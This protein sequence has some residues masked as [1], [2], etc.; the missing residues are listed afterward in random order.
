MIGATALGACF[1]Y[2]WYL[3]ARLNKTGDLLASLVGNRRSICVAVVCFF[4]QISW[5]GEALSA[6]TANTLSPNTDGQ[7]ISGR[8]RFVREFSSARDVT[9]AHPVLDRTLDI[10]A[11]PAKS[12]IPVDVLETPYAVTTDSGHRIFVTDVSA[13]KVHVFDFAHSKYFVLQDGD[14]HL[15]RPVGAAADREGNIYVTDSGSGAISVYD[16]RGKFSRY[17]KPSRGSESYFEGPA[18]I[19]VDPATQHIYVCDSPR[20]MVIVLDK[21]GHVLE[22]FGRRGGGTRAGEFRYPT[23]VVAALGELVVL[24][25]GNRRLQILDVQGHFQREIQLGYTDS[26]TG[27]AVDNNGG[28]YVSDAV[29][30]R[31]QVFGQEGRLLY[32][33]GQMGTK[34]GE[35][36]GPAGLWV[37]SGGCLYVVDAQNKRVQAFQID[38]QNAKGCR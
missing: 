36:D 19:A 35:F 5:A 33:F 12:G 13:K 27:L 17:L 38:Q 7:G 15:R 9:R 29:I 10:V 25:S 6:A 4:V 30:N 34:A 21:K 16:S 8:P 2:L 14:D 3:S 37:D 22:H 26:R 24:D 18:G 32:A 31:V 1:Q 11:G 23:Q 28:I 20:H